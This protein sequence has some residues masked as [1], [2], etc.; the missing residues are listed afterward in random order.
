[1]R[2][3]R[4]ILFLVLIVGSALGLSQDQ[5]ISA[6][7]SS[8]VEAERAFARAC[9]EKG[10]RA[11]FTEFFAAGGIAFQPQPVKY[12]ESVRE[13]PA[14]LQPDAV[15]IAWEP[16]FSDI[17]AAGD[18][19]YNTGPVTITD[20]IFKTR[21]PKYGF[22]FSV[23]KK[24]ADGQWKVALDLGVDTNEPYT[25]SREV[26]TARPLRKKTSAA[27]VNVEAA[28]T[29]LMNAERDFLKSAQTS[30]IVK[31]FAKHANVDARLHREGVPPI[32]GREA[33][34][35]FLAT[36]AFNQTWETSFSDV[37]QSGDMGYTYGSYE[38]KEVN[39]SNGVTEKG[40]YARVW[41]SDDDNQWQMVMEVTDALPP[42]RKP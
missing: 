20:K 13:Q 29:Q 27:K 21:P 33:I 37:A 35:Q 36:K 24:Q 34:T 9:L 25:G 38:M 26:K 40:Y 12:K 16:I 4:G 11:S 39:S 8:L 1:M 19:G 41:K 10:I 31:A 15:T 2:T 30:G 23:W 7:L 5:Q 32:L 28:R 3:N 22:F 17:S 18:M 42:E 6:A 14:S